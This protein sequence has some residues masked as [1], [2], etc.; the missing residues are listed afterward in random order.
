MQEKFELTICSSA[1]PIDKPY[2]KLN[3][4]LTKRLNRKD[5]WVWL[6]LAD[7]DEGP[8]G[9]KIA[10]IGDERYV[11]IEGIE[12]ET[13]GPSRG[14]YHHAAALN[15][16]LGC[17]HTRFVLFLDPDFYIV[18]KTW[19]DDVIAHMVN[20]NLAFFG[21]PWHPKLHNKYRHFPAVHCL[22]IDLEKAPV[23][24]LDF[25]PNL[26]KA[27]TRFDVTKGKLPL[28]LRQRLGPV[29][30]TLKALTLED[31]QSIGSSRDTGYLLF[32]QYGG[33]NSLRSEC[34]TP[35]FRPR[36]DFRGP[37]YAKSRLNLLIERALP[38]RMCF[39]PKKPNYYT[40]TGFRE[41]GYFDASSRQWEEFIWH[42]QPFGFHFRGYQ[43]AT[44]NDESLESLEE[45]IESLIR[46]HG[47]S[48]VIKKQS[49]DTDD[50]M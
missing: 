49:Y 10:G 44:R 3:W 36:S 35:V 28:I 20:N 2:I 1:I 8:P 42:D 5:G 22:F 31:R 23:E 41:M 19:M 45:A 18:R 25:T 17:I 38:D 24:S 43:Q 32:K 46:K 34:V 50:D 9:E 15:K 13:T 40:K 37:A 27:F 11:I 29:V 47:D 48:A 33:D 6:V 21:V 26:D 7:N 14:S 16:A 12:C 4:E 30:K 39:I